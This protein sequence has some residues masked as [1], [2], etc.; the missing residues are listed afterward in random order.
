[1]LTKHNICRGLIIS[2]VVLLIT[3]CATIVGDKTHLMDITSNP[4]EADITITD[5]KG[6]VVFTGKTPTIVTLQKSD[7][8][9]WGKK[10]YMVKISKAGFSE[11]T[12]AVTASANG[13]YIAGNIVFGGLIGWF[14]VDP[15]NGGMYNLSPKDISA[16][17]G[18][19]MSNSN[20]TKDG[21]VAIMLLQ[22][23]PPELRGKMVKIG[24]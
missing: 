22:D 13:W 1:M 19:K 6:L 24:R 16:V 12:I 7:G 15:F 2:A 14:I 9:Y 4:S 18:P 10:S 8:S 20:Q 5:E 3:A 17:L 21:N 11:Q 23:V